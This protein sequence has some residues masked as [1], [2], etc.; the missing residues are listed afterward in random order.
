ME[1]S[2][3]FT[4]DKV[5]TPVLILHNDQDAA[6]PWYQGIE[7]FMGLRRL[8]QPVWML[9]YNGEPHWPTKWENIRDYNIRMQQ[10]LDHYLMEQPMPVWMKEGVPAVLKG[11]DNGLSIED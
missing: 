3:I 6:V 2:P 8:N 5:K 1:N 11:I 10:Y 7:M 9:N 4:L